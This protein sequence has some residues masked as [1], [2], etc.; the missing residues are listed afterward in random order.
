MQI[1]GIIISSKNKQYIAIIINYVNIIYIT[2]SLINFYYQDLIIN[3][4]S[5][6]TLKKLEDLKNIIPYIML[7]KKFNI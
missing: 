2:L 7:Y 1:R 6:L 5:I 4:G 3:K